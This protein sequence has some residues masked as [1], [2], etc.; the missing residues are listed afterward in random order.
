MDPYEAKI[1][2]LNYLF[3]QYLVESSSRYEITHI[4]NAHGIDAVKLGNFLL[5]GQYVRNPQFLPGNRFIASINMEG[6]RW[7]HPEYINDCV[8]KVVNAVAISP[9]EFED[10]MDILSFGRDHLKGLDVALYMKDLGLV[11]VQARTPN[12][13][14]KLTNQ[15]IEYYNTKIPNWLPY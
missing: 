7:V 15:G 6:I 8:D 3:E 1:E 9:D 12:V 10:V 13:Y 2:A 5:R 14:V 11:E 4:A